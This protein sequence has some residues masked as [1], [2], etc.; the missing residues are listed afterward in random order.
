VL[1]HC[2]AGAPPWRGRS[3]AEVADRLLA[4]AEPTPIE[5]APDLPRGVAPLLRDALSLDPRQR[6]ARFRGFAAA[7]EAASR[8]ERPRSTPAYLRGGASPAYGIARI[9]VV[10][11]LLLLVIGS[12]RGGAVERDR[13][14]L[15]ARLDAALAP[16]PFPLHGEDPPIDPVGAQVLRDSATEALRWPRDAELLVSLGWARLRAGE[17][18]AAEDSF[19]RAA[20]WDPHSAEASISLGIARLERGDRAGALDL[21]R[22]LSR[23]PRSAR[24]RLIRGAGDLYRHR[25]SD[26]ADSFRR[27]I[28][29]DGPSY[30]AWFHL[31]LAAHLGGEDAAAEA[32]LAATAELREH[33]IW[34]Q[35]LEAERHLS[36][37]DRE[38][39]LARIEK[40]RTEWMESPAL[41]LRGAVLH[42]RL[43]LLPSAR[44]WWERARPGA[45]FPP[46][47]GTLRW[48]DRGLLTIPERTA[49]DP[50]GAPA[51][52]RVAE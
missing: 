31:A 49:S 1:H 3:E 29:V 45:E 47:P 7:L 4:G 33:E 24:E 16:R 21:E 28:G 43:G 26:A 44:E 22:G 10:V 17:R 19:A 41:L 6:P 35:W 34:L 46:D 40:S 5:P 12:I 48:S 27:S 30:A 51:P 39:A 18:A 11:M 8:G 38:A 36:R 9:A 2:L 37:G 25:F 13:R 50:F 32:A 52:S 14:A 23:A 15:L 20:L 42:L